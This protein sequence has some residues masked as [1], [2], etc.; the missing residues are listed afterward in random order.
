MTRTGRPVEH[1]DTTLFARWMHEEKLTIA[2]AAELLGISESAVKAY[3]YG[4]AGQQV[5]NPDKRMLLAMAAVSKGI[6]PYADSA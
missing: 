1:T 4:K 2:H 5:F 6:E 3:R